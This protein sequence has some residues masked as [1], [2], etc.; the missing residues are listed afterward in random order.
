[1]QSEQEDITHCPNTHRQTVSTETYT[2]NEQHTRTIAKRRLHDRWKAPEQM[3]FCCSKASNR[4]Y[5]DSEST[6]SMD[7]ISPAPAIAEKPMRLLVLR[8]RFA[9]EVVNNLHE[10]GMRDT[11]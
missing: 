10:S 1:V 11:V 3:E 4:G 5:L 7:G 6:I 9:K 2:N 8:L